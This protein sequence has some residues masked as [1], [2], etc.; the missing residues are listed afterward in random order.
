MIRSLSLRNRNRN[1]NSRRQVRIP[2]RSLG[3]K[4]KRKPRSRSYYTPLKPISIT[5][6]DQ[7]DEGT[8]LA[9]S[10]AHLIVKNVFEKLYPLKLSKREQDIYT[11]HSCND[12]LRTHQLMDISLI[13]ECSLHGY[14]KILLFLYVYFTAYDNFILKND[15][16]YLTKLIEFVLNLEYMPK[17]FDQ[18][19]H[20][21]PLLQIL[22]TIKQKII[23][24]NIIFN[25]V[26]I[27]VND[28]IPRKILDGDFYVAMN[29]SSEDGINSKGAVKYVGHVCTI[30]DHTP[31]QFIVKNTWLESIDY[32]P[33][34]E[35]K[36]VSLFYSNKRWSVDFFITVLPIFGNM[37]LYTG[38]RENYITDL[39]IEEGELHLYKPWVFNYISKF[40]KLIPS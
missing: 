12:F 38:I 29:L 18:T 24:Y 34:K 30:V 5:K 26:T 10:C 36:H 9:H 27:A 19:F 7:G 1:R 16:K 33:Y 13:N 15:K 3:S 31:T 37:D 21:T 14:Y 39:E 6:S 40:R 25:T 11:Q 28:L 23:K 22:K 35:L 4:S 32:V 20:L 8:C 17:I 2:F